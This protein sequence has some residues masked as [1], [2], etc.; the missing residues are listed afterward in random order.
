MSESEHG[1][2]IRTAIAGEFFVAAE[3]SKRGW[4]ATLTAK[5]TPGVDILAARPTGDTH[6]RIDV[7]ARSGTSQYSW[8]CGKVSMRG[9]RDFAVFVD[10]GDEDESPF[11]WIVP[12]R[13]AHTRLINNQTMK[14][15]DVEEFRD[16]W[17]L[18]DG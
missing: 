3:L 15:K 13:I 6:V 1:Q 11:Y 17:D 4:I 16:R 2:N 12:A 18:L 9:E 8:R 14:T 5:N 10:I 7:K